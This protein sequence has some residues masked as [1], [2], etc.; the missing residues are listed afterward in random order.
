MFRIFKE[1]TSKWTIP[2]WLV[3]L[4]DLLVHILDWADRLESIQG[5]AG[6]MMPLL[7]PAIGFLLSSKGQLMI[8]V[9]G[10]LLLFIATWRKIE[11]TDREK[12]KNNGL[13]QPKEPQ[14]IIVAIDELKTLRSEGERLVGRFQEDSVK[15][16]FVEV[17][18][19]RK[20]TRDC[21]RQNTLASLVTAK[22]LLT[23][24][25]PWE[26]GEVIKITAEFLDYGCFAYGSAQMAVFQHLWGQVQRLKELIAK[27][28]GEEADLPKIINPKA[29]TPIEAID[30]AINK[31]SALERIFASVTDPLPPNEPGAWIDETRSVLRNHAPDYVDKFNEAVKNTRRFNNFP[32][33]PNRPVEE[34][35]AWCQDKNRRAG[36]DA[37]DSVLRYLREIRRVIYSKLPS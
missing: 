30:E 28:E 1:L 4:F 18:D 3:L 13:I 2:G 33:R 14:P 8:L 6:R 36:W 29:Q 25:K 27:I 37:I 15:P 22:D 11:T 32:D 21:A 19:W 35:T 31:G 16:S 20:R 5:K 34:F 26:Q 24:E 12:K 7:K 23:L 17:E 9:I 10:L